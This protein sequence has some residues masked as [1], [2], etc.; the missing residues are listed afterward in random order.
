[1]SNI[2]I[3]QEISYPIKADLHHQEIVSA[4]KELRIAKIDLKDVRKAVLV[5]TNQAYKNAG[6]YKADQEQLKSELINI[7]NEVAGFLKRNYQK[8][9]LQDVA[10]AIREGSTGAYGDFFGVNAKTIRGWI[11][12][13]LS[14]RHVKMQEQRHHE[15]KIALK[16]AEEEREAKK[17]VWIN[18][19][20][21]RIIKTIES[22]S[23]DP[24]FKIYDYGNAMYDH[25][26]SMRLIPLSLDDKLKYIE[27]AKVKHL[28][29]LNADADQAKKEFN[30]SKHSKLITHINNINSGKFEGSKLQS[31]YK[32]IA[33][34]L[35]LK[36]F[37]INL[38]SNPHEMDK[39][40]SELKKSIKN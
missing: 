22:V 7:K 37:Y 12:D 14:V 21:N 5:L 13:Y 8:L 18:H 32:S 6:I 3:R 39:V 9:S 35:A 26:D 40:I 19:L 10:I 38:V 27:Q 29:D 30:R 17:H 36:D 34:K 20:K 23:S 16:T 24:K 2:V 4:S 25:L 1:M 28:E 31:E 15:Q 11:E 33:K